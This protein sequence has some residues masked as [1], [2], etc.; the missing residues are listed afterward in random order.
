MIPDVATVVGLEMFELNRGART[1]DGH[2]LTDPNVI[3]PELGL[4][5][6]LDGA[7]AQP[8]EAQPPGG[9]SSDDAARS[10]SAYSSRT[11]PLGSRVSTGSSDD[12]RRASRLDNDGTNFY[13]NSAAG[14]RI[15]IRAS[16]A[17]D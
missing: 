2:M 17:H 12:Q 13:S 9:V 6:P 5:V 8:T 10:V 14:G 4:Q 3:W 1:P 15:N 7:M 11:R 16:S